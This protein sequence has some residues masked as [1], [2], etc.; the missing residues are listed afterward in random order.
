[1]ADAKKEI[2]RKDLS[3]VFKNSKRLQKLVEQLLVTAKS[4]HTEI[5]LQK[6]YLSI[7]TIAHDVASCFDEISEKLNVK[8]FKNIQEDFSGFVDQDVLEKVMMNLL[9]NSFKYTK[10]GKAVFLYVREKNSS[11]NIEVIDEGVGLSLIHI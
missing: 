7:S 2:S 5:P 9:S 6:G 10:S 8:L 4:E 3:L 1:M 11:L